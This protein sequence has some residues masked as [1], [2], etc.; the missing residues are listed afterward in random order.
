MFFALSKGLWW[1]TEPVTF[2]ILAGLLGLIL[3]FMR[4]PGAGRML[5]AGAVVLMAGA[6]V[7]LA[8]GL[9]TPVGAILLRPLEERFPQPP[10]DL[11]PPAGIIVLGGDMDADK[12]DARGGA[13]V[14]AALE[15]ARRY[16]SAKVVYTG[17]TGAIFGGGRPEAIS[18]RQF[19]ISL[20]IPGERMII[21]AKS[22][23]TWENGLYTHDLVKPK[24]GEKWLL[25]TSAWHMPRSVGVF[26]QLGFD[27]IAY[28]V[29]YRTFGDGR[30]YLSSPSMAERVS[31]LELSFHEWMGLLAYWLTGKTDAL[32][33]SPS[34][35]AAQASNAPPA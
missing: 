19:L 23:N 24:H 35:E 34:K 14:A 22:R 2:A 15:L 25:V 6:V 17:R 21:E 27:V 9:L 3:G 4:F 26:R 30:D 20:G 13:R 5:M 1:I 16:P 8:A 33:P 32:F 11:P 18:A 28:P 10:T 12:T 29:D 7:A 31:G